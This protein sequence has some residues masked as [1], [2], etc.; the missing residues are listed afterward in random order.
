VVFNAKGM[1]GVG[2]KADIEN[3]SRLDAGLDPSVSRNNSVTEPHDVVCAR[4]PE[5]RQMSRLTD[6]IQEG[7]DPILAILRIIIDPTTKKEATHL[8][9]QAS[10]IGGPRLSQEPNESNKAF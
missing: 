9:R 6:L 3:L 10:V 2:G 1:S 8:P 4:A 5:R 7:S